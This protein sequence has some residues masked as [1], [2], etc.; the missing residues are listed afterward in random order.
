MRKEN[1]GPRIRWRELANLFGAPFG[2]EICHEWFGAS[3][4][5]R[6]CWTR[7][8]GGPGEGNLNADEL[9]A[10][11]SALQKYAWNQDCFFR[12]AELPFVTTDKPILFRGGLQELRTFLDD[13]KYR[14]TPEYWWPVDHS[15]CVCSDYDLMFTIVAG[16]KELISG[17][18][19]NATLEAIQ[20][21]PQTRI[22]SYAPMPNTKR[23]G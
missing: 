8:L 2:A 19:N 6:D 9:S 16:S 17:V 7:F 18:L 1:R 14:F 5:G 21:T 11:L 12:F 13:G 22:D 15:W 4:E 23:D 10:V 20:V 3:A